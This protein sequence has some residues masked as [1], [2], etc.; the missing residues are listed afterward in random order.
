M[1]G[2]AVTGA[3]KLAQKIEI[4]RLVVEPASFGYPWEN[5]PIHLLG[6]R[7]KRD[8]QRLISRAAAVSLLLGVAAALAAPKVHAASS[9]PEPE[10]EQALGI[11]SVMNSKLSGLSGLDLAER[12]RLHGEARA[13]IKFR[14]NLKNEAERL[15]WM[16]RCINGPGSIFCRQ[17]DWDPSEQVGLSRKR[18][19]NRTPQEEYRQAQNALLQ[20]NL[21]GFEELSDPAISRVF[22]RVSARAEF[23][24]LEK[25]VLGA[26]ACKAERVAALMGQKSEEYLPE[27]SAIESTI[28][29]YE[30]AASCTEGSERS[31]KSRYRGAL[32]SI[33]R[34]DWN[35]AI[36]LLDP[37]TQASARKSDFY[38]R[39]IYWK[40]KAEK[41]RGNSLSFKQ[42]A[43]RLTKEFPIH[44]HSLLLAPRV[45]FNAAQNLHLPEPTLAFESLKLGSQ[46]ND[47]SRA[48]E[49]LQELGATELTRDFFVELEDMMDG[50][51]AES[52]LYL[53]VLMHRNMNSI[54]T[55][56]VLSSLFREHPAMLSR[57]TLALFFPLSKPHQQA[58]AVAQG[59]GLDP[60]LIA[61]LIRQESGFVTHARSPAGALGLMQLMPSTARSMEPVSKQELLDSRTNVRLGVK[62]FR[63]LLDRFDGKVDH[64]LAAYNA[65]PLRVDEWQRRYPVTDPVLFV[66]LI[67]FKETREYVSLISRNYY[68]Y[69]QIYARHLFDER[70]DSAAIRSAKAGG[71]EEPASRRF[72]SVDSQPIRTGNKNPLEFSLF[73]S[74]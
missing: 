69:L 49:V 33:M 55:F 45:L 24:A 59:G 56:R 11:G 34:E 65:G 62:F 18:G 72:A 10:N 73:H 64:A 40:A 41:S 44:Y 19:R 57:Q 22:N 35:R 7:A 50:G 32:L 63:R 67:P 14:R 61:A 46:W 25:A 38:S 36:R 54:G 21:S 31:E 48:I 4:S 39:A 1:A 15:A 3:K 37:L 9:L 66:D 60:Y 51:E 16:N 70:L 43:A 12:N 52:R 13:Y 47:R 8:S 53:A 74:H 26:D 23:A 6:T 20:G 27:T 42:L 58:L 29:L 2:F 68:W 28:S 17:K 5:G 71:A 30:K